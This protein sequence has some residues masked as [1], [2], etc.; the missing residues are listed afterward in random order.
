MKT[1]P[2]ERASRL[3]LFGGSAAY[4][5]SWANFWQVWWA[6]TAGVAAIDS[7]RLDRFVALVQFAREHSPLYR[8]MYRSVRSN[9][10]APHALPV[11]TK[12]ALMAHSTSGSPTRRFAGRTLM[13]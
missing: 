8:E 1:R 9:V 2:A 7:T 13:R 6:H 5:R 3:P 12:H 11:V 4:V 10:S